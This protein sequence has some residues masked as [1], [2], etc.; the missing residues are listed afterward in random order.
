MQSYS[1]LKEETQTTVCPLHYYANLHSQWVVYCQTTICDHAT[2]FVNVLNLIFTA[3]GRKLLERDSDTVKFT[4]TKTSVLNTNTDLW[5]WHWCDFLI[6]LQGLETALTTGSVNT[7]VLVPSKYITQTGTVT[8]KPRRL[9]TGATQRHFSDNTIFLMWFQLQTQRQ[10]ISI[11]F[12]NLKFSWQRMLRSWSTRM[13]SHVFWWK[14]TNV[15]KVHAARC[16]T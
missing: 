14:V 1:L 10:K 11:T 4:P 6:Q 12:W 9:N 7:D 15:L 16:S 2:V 5:W 8:T 3:C 13:Q